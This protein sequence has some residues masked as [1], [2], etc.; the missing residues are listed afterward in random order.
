MQLKHWL[1]ENGVS[2]RE[3]A[4]RIGLAHGTSIYRY[5]DGGRVPARKFLLRI[6][7]ETR[8]AVTPDDFY[9]QVLKK[10]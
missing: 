5:L 7:I 3:F 6:V 10:V 9:R 8:G 2:P 4:H 1:L